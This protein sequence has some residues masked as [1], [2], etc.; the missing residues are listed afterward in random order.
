MTRG[1]ETSITNNNPSE[2][3]P[4]AILTLTKNVLGQNV[5]KTIEPMIKRFSVVETRDDPSPSLLDTPLLET[6]TIATSL[7]PLNE[8]STVAITSLMQQQ[9]PQPQF[10]SVDS[11]KKKTK[12]K[13]KRKDQIQPEKLP[14]KEQQLEPVV[15][16]TTEKRKIS[17]FHT[18]SLIMARCCVFSVFNKLCHNF[19]YA[20]IECVSCRGDLLIAE[21]FCCS[22][23]YR[24]SYAGL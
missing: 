6:T 7:S 8:L 10:H 5:T 16:I 19:M 12:S 17:I 11:K 2:N 9:Q 13:I 23:F 24:Y 1:Q 20:A 15:S 4:N 22:K 14:V 3:V 18:F 21:D